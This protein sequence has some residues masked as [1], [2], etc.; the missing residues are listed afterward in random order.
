[1]DW[2]IKSYD[3]GLYES[4]FNAEVRSNP[5]RCFRS[6]PSR[7]WRRYNWLSEKDYAKCYAPILVLSRNLP[8]L[9]K[10]YINHGCFTQKWLF[11]STVLQHEHPLTKRTTPPQPNFRGAKRAQLKFA[12][13]TYSAALRCS[14]PELR[15]LWRN[16]SPSSFS[17]MGKTKFLE[18]SLASSRSPSA[19]KTASFSP[20]SARKFWDGQH[21][22]IFHKCF[23]SNVH[24][25]SAAFLK[26]SDM[27]DTRLVLIKYPINHEYV[28]PCKIHCFF[29]I[30]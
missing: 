12:K 1:M 14:K 18:T 13:K 2:T 4:K 29:T 27:Y 30:Y 28:L 24:K 25:T 6:C 16:I 23:Y 3:K 11:I 9:P 22:C 20:A 21:L 17:A 5:W 10:Q 7:C 19:P 26:Y 15:S 8:S